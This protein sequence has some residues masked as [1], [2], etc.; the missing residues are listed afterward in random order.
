MQLHPLQVKGVAE[1]EGSVAELLL[2]EHGWLRVCVL[3]APREALVY[4]I[5]LRTV[6]ELML[7]VIISGKLRGNWF[8]KLLMLVA[9]CRRP[10]GKWF[11]TRR[12]RQ[13]IGH[14]GIGDGILRLDLRLVSRDVR[15]DLPAGSHPRRH[16]LIDI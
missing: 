11:F 9:T 10:Y 8:A 5:R 1:Q 12:L 6:G 4:S 3:G 15:E 13:V 16:D 7:L 14:V 2:L